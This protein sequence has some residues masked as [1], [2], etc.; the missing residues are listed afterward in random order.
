MKVPRTNASISPQATI[1]TCS[2][3]VVGSGKP[4]DAILSLTFGLMPVAR[5]YR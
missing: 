5:N 1:F 4:A 3:I 2:N